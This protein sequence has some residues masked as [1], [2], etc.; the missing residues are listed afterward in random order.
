MTTDLFA[1]DSY[2]PGDDAE[3]APRKGPDP[4]LAFALRWWWLLLVGGL[5][6]LVAAFGYVRLGPFPYASVAQ[7]QVPPQTVTNPNATSDQARDA[8][9]N[10]T[11]EATTSQM[12][13][14]ISQELA[15]TLNLSA[16][17]LL[18][19]QQDGEIAIRTVKG[20]NFITITVTDADPQRARLIADTIATVF[21]RDVNSRASA[22]ID[23]RQRLLE[24]QIDATSQRFLTARLNQRQEELQRDLSNQR[25]VLLQLQASSQQEL[26]RQAELDRVAGP[27][28]QP[29]P[30]L[31]ATRA[32]WLDLLNSQIAD[33]E[34]GIKDLTAQSSGVAAQLAKLPNS[35][36]PSVS[37]VFATA[38]GEQLQSLTRDYAQLQLDSPG[39]RAPLVRYGNASDPLPASGMKKILLLGGGA[40]AVIAAALGF[41]IDWLRRRKQAQQAQA[42]GVSAP[43]TAPASPATIQPLPLAGQPEG[44]QARR[45][46]ELVYLVERARQRREET[47][48]QDDAATQQLG[49]IIPTPTALSLRRRPLPT[50]EDGPT[51]RRIAK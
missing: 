36:D 29:S 6:G 1:D 23:A 21:V 31:A 7:V 45:P 35:T 4:Y 17:D 12:F 28:S 26:Q 13:T 43:T 49:K 27:G 22:Q 9:T 37:A 25:T 18:T 15:G 34:K 33:V 32:Q 39:A 14:L 50:Q 40:G 20:T 19:L 47:D 11:A 38:Y 5:L 24:Q 44:A 3:E 42:E 30:Q 10:Y 2:T 8:T 16:S 41:A 48:E 46:D 51:I